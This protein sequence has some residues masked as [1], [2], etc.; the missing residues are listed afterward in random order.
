ME[1]FGGYVQ[2]FHKEVFWFEVNGNHECLSVPWSAFDKT[3]GDVFDY[4][5][6][7]TVG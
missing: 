1:C 2:A 7:C 5:G 4:C 3:C 6:V